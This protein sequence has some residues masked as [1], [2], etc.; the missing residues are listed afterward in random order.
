MTTKAQHLVDLSLRIQ[1]SGQDKMRKEVIKSD[2]TLEANDY[3]G[4]K[5]SQKPR[6]WHRKGKDMTEE[7]DLV[8][9][10]RL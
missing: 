10:R 8:Y 6:E 9:I 4:T 2:K 7:G 1:F 3:A 5:P